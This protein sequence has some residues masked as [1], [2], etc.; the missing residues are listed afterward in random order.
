MKRQKRSPLIAALLLVMALTL[1]ACGG[2]MM[3]AIVEPGDGD[4][5]GGNSCW[6]PPG[7]DP[8]GDTNLEIAFN[9]LTSAGYTPEMAAGI[10]GNLQSESAGAQPGLAEWDYPDQF[11]WNVSDDRLRG[12]GIVQWTYGRHGKVRDYVADKLGRE[13]YV[14]QYSSPTAEEWLDDKKESDLL[15]VQLE[16]LLKEMQDPYYKGTVYDPMRAASTPEAAAEIFLRKFEIPAGV[17]EQVPIRAGQ[18]RA[19]YDK[20]KGGSS[21]NSGGDSSGTNDDSNDKNDD[22]GSKAYTW[23][24][25]QPVTLTSPYGMRLHPIDKVW[26]LHDGIDYGGGGKLYAFADGT[27]EQ[28]TFLGG[29]GNRVV[30]RLSN[31]QALGYNHLASIDVKVGDK[32]KS[33]DVLGVMGTTGSS[34]GV[35][36]HFNVYKANVPLTKENTQDPAPWLEKMG[37]DHKTGKPNGKNPELPPG[38]GPGDDC[39]DDGGGGGGPFPEKGDPNDP[40]AKNLTPE[41]LRL[42]TILRNEFPEVNDIGGYRPSSGNG[43]DDHTNGFALDIMVYD[44]KALGDRIAKFLTDNAEELDVDYQIWYQRIWNPPG[45]QNGGSDAPGQWRKME[46]RGSPTENHIDHVHV[47]TINKGG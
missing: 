19:H 41:T 7:V 22:G 14:S 10:T 43:R 9:Y 32:V 17:E 3:A 6:E 15:Q 44:D 18:A 30:L 12:W 24:T 13:Y 40:S 36:L 42:L 21:S 38:E 29:W 33:G 8:V 4:D 16:Y 26:K 23:M 31:G 11:G 25:D 27:I 37:F 20:W 5:D 46:D 34:T 1:S 35:H 45:G 47:T 39:N 2:G 28:A